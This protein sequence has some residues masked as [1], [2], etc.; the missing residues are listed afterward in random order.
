VGEVV[1]DDAHRDVALIKTESVS[2]VKPLHVTMAE[3]A[4]GEDVFAIGSPLGLELTGTFTRG[5]LSGQRENDGLEYLQSDV[6]V[7]PGNSGGPLLDG[8]SEVI[9]MAVLLND[10][11][12][13]LAF[14]IPIREAANALQ[15]VFD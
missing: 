4:V 6:A 8:S 13:G 10:K 5:V 9:G 11:A 2:E 12:H 1:R 3:Q 14:F 15:L 7:N